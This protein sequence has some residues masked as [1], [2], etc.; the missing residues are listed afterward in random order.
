MAESTQKSNKIGLAAGGLGALVLGAAQTRPE[1][2]I[3]NLAGWLELLGVNNVPSFLATT[4]ADNWGTVVGITL[5]ALSALWWPWRRQSRQ[6]KQQTGI[7]LTGEGLD[8][9]KVSA[10]KSPLFETKFFP[11]DP[12]KKRSAFHRL[13]NGSWEDAADKVLADKVAKEETERAAQHAYEIEKARQRAIDEA[14]QKH[15]IERAM[16][17][18]QSKWFDEQPRRND[19]R[20]ELREERR[21]KELESDKHRRAMISACRDIV[22]LFHETQM[23]EPFGIYLKKNRAFLDIQPFLGNEYW[24]GVL[25][26]AELEGVQNEAPHRDYEAAMFLRELARLQKEWKL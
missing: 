13:I 25:G 8:H 11:Q 3:S 19:R 2:A 1:D 9:L 6:G 10:V 17:E 16:A 14:T 12:P 4:E 20:A 15:S 18:I 26:R 23:P 5:V 7:W 24:K 22:H 21:L